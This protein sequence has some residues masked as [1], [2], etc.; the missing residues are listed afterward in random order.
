MSNNKLKLEV[1]KDQED[2]AGCHIIV[3]ARARDN[4]PL[5]LPDNKMD[6]CSRCGH[7]VQFRPNLPP[8]PE[9][10][11]FDCMQPEIDAEL[12]KGGEVTMLITPKTVREVSEYIRKQRKE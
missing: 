2:I 1:V 4:E 10:V 11:C 8:G 5:L 6:F 3:C 7:K 12:A 9:F